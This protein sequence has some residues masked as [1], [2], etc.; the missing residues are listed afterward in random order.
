M[1]S[2]PTRTAVPSIASTIP[3]QPR[4]SGYTTESKARLSEPTT[5]S[6][7]LRRK[8]LCLWKYAHRAEIRHAEH[9]HVEWVHTRCVRL[10]QLRHVEAAGH[11]F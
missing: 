2:G 7:D 10:C 6:G 4:E 1:T 8:E 11:A 3:L 9:V 5:S